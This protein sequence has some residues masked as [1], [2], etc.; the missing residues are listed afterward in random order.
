MR[1]KSIVLDGFKSYAHRREIADLSPHF[2]AITGLNGSGKSNIFDAVCFVMGITNL[3]RMRAE[4]PRELIYRAGTTGVHAARV[5]IEFINDDPATAPPGYSCEDCPIITV[6]RQI[7][8]GGKQQFF[9]NNVVSMQSRVKRFFESIGLNVDSPHFMIL[10]GTV[11]QLVSMRSVAILALIEEAVGTKAFDHRR[12]TA[13]ALIRN[14]EKRMQEIDDNIATQICPLLDVLRA[15]QEAYQRY[16]TLTEG[17]EEKRAFRRGYDYAQHLAQVQALEERRL[18]TVNTIESTKQHLEGLPAREDALTRRLLLVQSELTAPCEASISLHEEESQ[19]RQEQSRLQSKV[20]QLRTR[21]KAVSDLLKRLQ[22]E[23]VSGAAAAAEVEKEK[24]LQATKR[25]ELQAKREEAGKLKHSLSLL[26]SG[27]RAGASGVSLEE[28]RQQLEVRRIQVKAALARDENALRENKEALA[29][30]E[31]KAKQRSSAAQSLEKSVKAAQATYDGAR[32]AFLKVEPAIEEKTQAEEA[33]RTSRQ[34]VSRAFEQFQRESGGGLTFDIAFNRKACRTPDVDS[35]IL[36]RVGEILMPIDPKYARALVVGAQQQLLRVVVDRDT[37]VEEIIHAGLKQRISFIPLNTLQPPNGIPRWKERFAEAQRLA[38]E[39][40]G[41]VYVSKE[42]VTLRSQPG[43]SSGS[44]ALS[45]SATEAL[46]NTVFSSFVVCS[47][48]RLAEAIAYTPST[49]LKAVTFDGEAADPSGIM[50]GGSVDSIR[51]YFDELAVSLTRKAPLLR[52]QA[53]LREAEARLA[54]ARIAVEGSGAVVEQYRDAEERLEFAQLRFQERGGDE[55]LKVLAALQQQ[56]SDLEERMR[57]A[58]GELQ[59]VS[60]RLVDVEAE[61]K[62]DVAAAATELKAR[63]KALEKE[64]TRMAEEEE[65]AI[66]AF[67]RAS[68][69]AEERAEA[70]RQ[71]LGEA[72]AEQEV[73]KQERLVEERLLQDVDEKL[74]SVMARCAEAE[75]TRQR[76]EKEIEE[77]QESIAR[78]HE[79]VQSLTSI[80]R[81][82]ESERHS[83]HRQAED[84]RR[85]IREE[86]RQF[87]WLLAEAEKGT[88]GDVNGP[89]YYQDEART[90][91]TLQTLAEAEAHSAAMSRRVSK[92]ASVVLFEERQREYEELVQQR[93]AL[94]KD[95]EAIEACIAGIETRKWKA[96]DTM[97]GVVS[98]V[99][100]KLFETCLPGASAQLAE[101]RDTHGHLCGLGI[102]VKF[103]GKLKE[104]LTELSGGQ[105]SLLA[106]CLILSILRVRQAPIYILDEV[107]AALDPSHTQNIGVMLNT[108]FPSSQFLL[109][110]LK[111]GMFRNA[112]VVYHVR[113]HQGYSEVSRVAQ[114]VQ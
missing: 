112:N 46:I 110:S 65:Q 80:V 11:H 3:K 105:R 49:R 63:L 114:E 10:Q 33:V 14:K 54:R 85:A 60:Q 101:E 19:H 72:D 95:K 90:A 74:Q 1:V 87:P 61:A 18:S 29:A 103:N 88:L 53:T 55:Q 113:N 111:D 59:T 68:A 109:V 62:V 44:S 6:G 32:A 108:Y 22:K 73:V 47:S 25:A 13:E 8:L 9:F 43:S 83:L 99:F 7:K 50:T 82:G 77:V 91:A 104:S 21:E 86:E 30:V 42:L 78:L 56:G 75:A 37:V 107:D 94:G 98:S 48:L 24:A 4:D 38:R 52:E 28:E 34:A 27:V 92:K 51:N 102:Q 97:V 79:Q 66:P 2:N 67:E 17:L 71:R 89:F 12:R 16:L 100:G 5:T 35:H 70:L 57:E 41:S 69:E 64:V 45:P 40:G 84:I 31:K 15:D 39:M 106:L 76:M 81:D 23:Q 36:G 58:T 20:N 96:L 93:A 26:Q